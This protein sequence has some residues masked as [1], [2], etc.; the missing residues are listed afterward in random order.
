MSEVSI[1]VPDQR[2]VLLGLYDSALPEVYG[3][4]AS[5]CGSASVAED[6]TSETFLAAVDAVRRGSV[7]DLTVAWLIG[8]ARH[9][10]VDHW[11]RREREDRLLKA[12]DQ[13]PGDDGTT[14]EDPWD[15]QLDALIAHRTLADLAPQHRSAL[16]LRYLDGLPVREV[17]SCLGRTEGA[18]EV[19]LVRAKA[20]FRAH[21]EG[22]DR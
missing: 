9:K 3:Y 14:G 13:Q 21:Y 6:L 12:V 17:A 4:L 19:L 15:V 8:V 11:R 2:R 5:R 7:P 20:A 10:L 16:T 1:G 22:E 18:T